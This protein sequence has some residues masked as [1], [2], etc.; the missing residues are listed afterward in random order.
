[1]YPY[2]LKG[3]RKNTNT[4]FAYYCV[5]DHASS[6]EFYFDKTNRIFLQNGG[7][8]APTFVLQNFSFFLR[9]PFESFIK[10]ECPYV[11][12]T[13]YVHTYMVSGYKLRA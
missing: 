13:T 5:S 4:I 3:A 8:P 11:L 7:R 10:I 12:D 2:N 1:M 9:A 6:V